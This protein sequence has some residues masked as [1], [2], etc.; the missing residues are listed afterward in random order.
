MRDVRQPVHHEDSDSERGSTLS[1]NWVD[2][3]PRPEDITV[4]I[5]DDI[6]EEPEP[7]A[8]LE[9]LFSPRA[10]QLEMLE[11]SLRRNIIVAVKFFRVTKES[12]RRSNTPTDGYGQRENAHSQRYFS[13][14]SSK[15]LLRFI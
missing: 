9:T 1:E 6:H 3:Q 13:F 15:Y 8:S 11:E 12:A 5:N 4:E 7:Q 10:Y 14:T 2:D